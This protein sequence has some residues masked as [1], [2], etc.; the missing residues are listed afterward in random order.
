[1]GWDGM[2]WNRIS[3]RIMACVIFV[4]QIIRLSVLMCVCAF[5]CL[6]VYR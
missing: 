5:F 1:M 4:Q 3:K 6:C 2:E